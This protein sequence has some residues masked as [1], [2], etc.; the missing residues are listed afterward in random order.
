M[1][2]IVE[3]EWAPPEGR[4]GA[5]LDWR[6]WEAVRSEGRSEGRNAVARW[7]RQ[8]R[9]M[10]HSR[11]AGKQAGRRGRARCRTERWWQL[12]L[13]TQLALIDDGAA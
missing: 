9:H 8:P 11:Q 5:G 2:G 6:R 12:G 3:G 1:R 4:G 13:L 10:Q 7:P